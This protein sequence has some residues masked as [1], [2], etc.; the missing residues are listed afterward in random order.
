LI[1]WRWTLYPK[2]LGTAAL[3]PIASMW[4]G[5][6]RQVLE[7]LSEQLLAADPS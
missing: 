3:R 1:T 5:Y 6:A 2:R 4:R 7:L